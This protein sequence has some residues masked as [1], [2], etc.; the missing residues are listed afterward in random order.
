MVIRPFLPGDRWPE[1][2]AF[3][4]R[5]YRPDLALLWRPLFEWQYQSS[6]YGGNASMLTAWEGDRLVAALG[7]VSLPL[8]WGDWEE[9]V[10]GAWAMN[11]MVE[12]EYRTGVG[13]V[14]L[15]RLQEMHPVVFAIDASAQNLELVG[16]LGWTIAPV[17]PRMVRILDPD[18][19]ASLFGWARNA[20]GT[21][22]IASPRMASR[23]SELTH[24]SH[25]APDWRLYEPLRYGT[26]RSREHL[27]WR[28][29]QHPRFRYSVLL[30]ESTNRPAVCAY[31]VEMAFDK[32][33]RPVAPVG[34]V[35]DFFF[36]TDPLGEQDAEQLIHGVLT[37]MAAAGCVY[38]DFSGSAAVY[39]RLLLRLGWL[40][41]SPGCPLLPS[42]LTPVEPKP[43]VLNVEFGVSDPLVVPDLDEAYITTADGDADRPA[44]LAERMPMAVAASLQ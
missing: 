13:W 15:R 40:S 41:E 19:A 38:A 2:H 14:L 18:R 42:R 16:P 44:M 8:F 17:L 35:L 34:R 20:D 31:R 33:G 12:P 9:P 30:T 1:M 6:R 21:A 7:Y 11:W 37:R 23:L 5:Q 10:N 22:F 36:P 25:Y 32:A 43:R 39:R 27:R 3:L 28:F 24:D 4:S 26:L 29:L